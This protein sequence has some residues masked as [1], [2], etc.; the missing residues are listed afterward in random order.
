MN[1][2][3]LGGS[4]SSSLS[5]LPLPP[6]PSPAPHHRSI[7]G[8]PSV[9][10]L[11]EQLRSAHVPAPWVLVGPDCGVLWILCGSRCD[12]RECTVLSRKEPNFPRT[13]FLRSS[14]CVVQ[15]K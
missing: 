6:S 9:F 13:C 8:A 10:S 1:R 11:C 4:S 2:A 3:V 14:L 12:A 15:K 5:S 7:S